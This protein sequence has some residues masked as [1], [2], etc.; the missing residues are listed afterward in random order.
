M[1]FADT[2]KRLKE[3]SDN[4]GHRRVRR[5]DG[6]QVKVGHLDLIDLLCDW[7]R[8]DAE[9]RSLQPKPEKQ[10]WPNHN[11]CVGCTGETCKGC[12]T[13]PLD[14]RKP[15]EVKLSLVVEDKVGID[16]PKLKEAC[17]KLLSENHVSPGSRDGA[18]MI[19]SFWFG[20]CTSLGQDF[21]AGIKVLMD[22]GRIDECCTMP[23]AD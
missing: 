12:G 18:Q 22:C 2:L 1:S 7:T 6:D 10:P 14:R 20:A 4:P 15:S 16:I 11:Y 13:E 23:K 8:L 19:F 21:P 5:P 17:G 3:L 9:V